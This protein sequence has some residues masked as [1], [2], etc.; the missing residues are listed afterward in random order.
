MSESEQDHD[1]IR[2]KLNSETAHMPWKDLQRFFAAGDTLYV[3]THLD[4]IQ[5]AFAFQQNQVVDVEHWL[6][7]FELAPVSI[8]QAKTWLKTDALLWTVV[9]KPWIL[10]QLPSQP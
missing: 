7:Q 9:V 3:A 10:V 6:A 1:L 5:V 4:L 8:E 2:A